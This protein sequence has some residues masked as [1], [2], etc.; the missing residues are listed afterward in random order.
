MS[1]PAGPQFLEVGRIGKAH[2]LNGEVVVD[3]ITDRVRER[4]AV[5]A[6]LWHGGT[7][8]QVVAARP[9]KNKWL[10]RFADVTTREGDESLRE[11]TLRAPCLDDA[12]QMSVH[13]LIGKS[14]VDQYE[15]DHGP[16]VAVVENPAS[17]LLELADG[18]LVPL[19]FYVSSDQATV[20]V[21]VPAGLLDD[22]DDGRDGDGR[23][24]DSTAAGR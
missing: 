9:H 10:I 8:L 16:I 21:T 6:E 12:D 18:R 14:L 2:G 4:T 3:F 15:T 24:G 22:D 13:I 5:G 20:F 11:V 23:D 1:E 19:A 7:C 17:D